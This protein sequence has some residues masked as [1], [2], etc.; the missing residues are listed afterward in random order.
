M[1]IELKC[2]NAMNNLG[3]YYE[4]IEKNYDLM[5]KYYLMAIELKYPNAMKNLGLYYQD[6]EKNYDLMK[7]Y[8]L[9]AIEF[10]DVFAMNNLGCY[11]HNT[12]KNYDLMKKYYLM[13]IELNNVVSMYTL[14]YYYHYDEK[15]YDLMKK[16]YLMAIELD[17]SNALFGM[18]MFYKKTNNIEYN[19]Y[20]DLYVEKYINNTNFHEKIKKLALNDLHYDLLTNNT[21]RKTIIYKNKCNFMSKIGN[22]DV[23]MEENIQ[24]IPFECCHYICTNCYIKLDKCHLC[25]LS[26]N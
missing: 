1:A 8:Y 15:D 14:G 12:E 3:L 25:R 10:N 20:L 13:A 4:N 5:K 11:Y 18:I 7:K 24:L 19:K 9:M 22:C 17:N 2:T 23:C 26:I 16:Y 6:I 21:N